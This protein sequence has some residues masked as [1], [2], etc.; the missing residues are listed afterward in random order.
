MIWRFAIGRWLVHLGLAVMPPS[1]AR[2]ELY[3][4]FELWGTRVS[5]LVR[6]AKDAKP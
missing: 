4:L 5:A 3:Q 1:R 2:A 6:T